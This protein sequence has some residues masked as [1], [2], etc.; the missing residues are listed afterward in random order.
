MLQDL[1]YALRSLAK[2]PAVTLIAVVTLA[3]GIGVNTT[4]F[5]CVNALFLRPYPYREPSRLMAIRSD[6]P[7]RGFEGSSVSYPNF[8][9]WRD[10]STR[11]EGMVAYSGRSFNLASTD[12][13][14]RLEG[15]AISWNTFRLLGI[16]P[17]LGRDVREDE[18]RPGGDKVVLL[19][20]ALWLRRFGGDSSVVGRA[21]LLNGEPHTVIG[22]VPP[23]YQ[24]QADAQLWVPLQLDP[25]RMRDNMYLEVVGRLKPGTGIAEAQ[26]EVATIAGRLAEQYPETNA[27]WTASVVPWRADEVGKYKPVLTIMMGAVAFVLLIACANV[28]NLLLARA[29]ARNREIAIRGALGASR[30][31]IVRQLLTE[32]VLLALGGAAVGI[33]IALW[34]LDLIVAAVPRDK[35]FWMVFTVD[36]RVLA[37]TI[38]LAVGTGVLFGLA[39]AFQMTRTDL[40]ESLKEGARGAGGSGPRHR[41]RN[42]LVVAEV[43]LSLVLLVGATLM[44]RSFLALQRVDL[45]FDRRNVLA[46]DVYLAGSAYDSAYQ[47]TAFYRNL[48]PRLAT[49]PGVLH[50]TA[51]QAPPLSGSSTSTTFTIEGQS[52]E[53]GKKPRARLQVVTAGYVTAL[54]IP[55]LRGRDIEEHD[56]RDS[57]RVAVINQTMSERFWPGQDPLGRRFQLGM[58]GDEWFTVIGVAGDVK[59]YLRDPPQN[60]VYI[61]YGHAAYRGMTILART[62]GDASNAV[63]AAREAVRAVDPQLPVDLNT[64]E[65]MFRFQTWEQRLYG[66]MFGSFA[67]VALLLAA[68]GLYGVMA[69]MVTLRT[70]EIGVRMALGAERGHVLRLV[71]RR[72][73]M[74]TGIGLAIGF[75]GAFALTR[76]LANLLFGVTTTDAP[77]FLGIPALLAAVALLA[78][79]VPARRAARVDPM[80]ALRYE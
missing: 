68:V 27:G 11:F 5:S 54:R 17:L 18:D 49:V 21:L 30:W 53:H 62:A 51:S 64:M 63:R 22:V 15:A 70:H 25:T 45:G 26:A 67:G 40:H 60:Q 69:Y 20:S 72:G 65:G 2:T 13:P 76:V 36:G 9:D 46:L 71:V 8:A 39:P 3:L 47:R 74:L 19:S 1:R 38:T 29:T 57:A 66:W 79:Y 35:P 34:G 32:S 33:L 48:L 73:L 61:P 28:A 58:S 16:T 7:S 43:A 31:R 10:Q 14:E 41:L 6:N 77:S 24:Y 12:E 44:I 50:A 80:L 78:S 42:T 23:P 52:V 75:V 56:M 37:F 59:Q 55:L 4:V